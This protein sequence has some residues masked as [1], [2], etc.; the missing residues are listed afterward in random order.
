MVEN[1]LMKS[2]QVA[3]LRKKIIG[4][5]TVF[6]LT[7]AIYND[8][9]GNEIEIFLLKNHNLISEYQGRIYVDDIFAAFN[10][11]EIFRDDLLWEFISESFREYIENPNN[12]KKKSAEL[13]NF[14]KGA[15][16]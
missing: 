9:S 12:L 3:E 7:N 2:E 8:A 10:S 16:E 13:Y 11:K 6:D 15:V 1:K 5:V 14:I 4:N